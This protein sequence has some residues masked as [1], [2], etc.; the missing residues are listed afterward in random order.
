[1]LN[2]QMKS[3]GIY[4]LYRRRDEQQSGGGDYDLVDDPEDGPS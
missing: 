3:W 4:E 2:P 1:M